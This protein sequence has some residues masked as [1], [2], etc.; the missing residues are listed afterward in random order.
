[1]GDVETIRHSDKIMRA[2][3]RMVAMAIE[4]GADL[5]VSEKNL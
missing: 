4:K 3:A 5:K 1:M 2:W